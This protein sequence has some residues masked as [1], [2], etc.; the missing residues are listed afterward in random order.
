MPL[1]ERLKRTTPEPLPKR[2]GSPKQAPV[3][4]EGAPETAYQELKSR[5]H[6]QLF[7]QLDLSKLSKVSEE[8]MRRDIANAVA[9]SFQQQ[10]VLGKTREATLMLEFIDT[11]TGSTRTRPLVAHEQRDP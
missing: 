11:L 1:I 6:N 5:V 9:T 4:V 7:E 8:Q 3:P 2:N 10:S